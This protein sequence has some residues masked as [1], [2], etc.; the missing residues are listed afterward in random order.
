MAEPGIVTS[1]R[2]MPWFTLIFMA[3]LC[4][5]RRRRQ[6]TRTACVGLVIY[7]RAQFWSEHTRVRAVVDFA[8][9]AGGFLI[10]AFRC[11]S[12]S[13][14]TALARCSSSMHSSS[15]LQ[16]Y[17]TRV[18]TPSSKGYVSVDLGSPS[19]GASPS[20]QRSNGGSSAR[21]AEPAAR[22]WSLLAFV[23]KG[24]VA[25][26]ASVASVA[27]TIAVW[28]LAA[29]SPLSGIPAPSAGALA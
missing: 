18:G 16:E 20:S 27:L 3:A 14:S 11:I 5:Q 10:L 17:G 28:Q 15:A 26:L 24:T 23:A 19:R 8:S 2:R 22:A 12:P 6:A 13:A 4:R 21:A 9:S 25:V 29:R 1:C 7:S